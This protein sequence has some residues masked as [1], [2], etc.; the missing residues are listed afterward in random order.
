MLETIT[1][2]AQHHVTANK[3]AH[4]KA[5]QSYVWRQDSRQKDTSRQLRVQETTGMNRRQDS[6]SQVGGHSL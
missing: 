6:S 4:W 3:G 1:V 2:A 5:V